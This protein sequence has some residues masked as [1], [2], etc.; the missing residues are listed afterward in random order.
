M[1]KPYV[2]EKAALLAEKDNA[3][4]FE[5]S[6]TATKTG[7]IKAI[8][9]LYNVKPTK[10][11]IINLPR[12]KVFVRGKNGM[13]KAIRKAVVFLKKGDKIDLA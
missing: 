12:K 6:K 4:T 5:I 3:Y 11:N 7:I 1:V 9:T 8:N 2:T 13:T 10:V